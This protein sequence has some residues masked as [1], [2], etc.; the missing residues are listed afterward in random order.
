MIRARGLLAVATAA[1]LASACLPVMTPPLEVGGGG[2]ARLGG[3]AGHRF[4][5]GTH[6]ASLMPDAHFPL[7]VGVGYVQTG[8]SS[9]GAEVLVHGLYAEGGP[10]LAG[11]RFWRV[12]AGPRAEYYFLPQAPDAAYAGL[13][14]SSIELMVPV[15]FEGVTA[16]STER[17]FYAGMAHGML[18]L[19]AYAEGGWQRLPTDA[20]LPVVGG[21]LNIRIPMTLG[22]LCCVWD[23]KK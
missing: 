16:E 9:A 4:S 22:L 12:F 10:R 3:T 15:V 11:G 18:A 2:A 5:A 21:G 1:L 23:L 8:T 13:L 19:G 7:D 20:A 6:V 14:R 17:S